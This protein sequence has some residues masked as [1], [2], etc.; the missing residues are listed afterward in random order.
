MN[1]EE[2]AKARHSA[3][4]FIKEEKMTEEDFKKIFDLTK[5]AP[6]AYNLQLTNYLVITDE[7]KKEFVYE[8]SHQTI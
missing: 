3:V 6:S 1:F 7:E 8:N 2:L 5:L 4:N